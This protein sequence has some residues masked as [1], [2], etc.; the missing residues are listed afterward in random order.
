MLVIEATQYFPHLHPDLPLR[1]REIVETEE[2][3]NRRSSEL[4]QQGYSVLS[5]PMD[6][7]GEE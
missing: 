2:D 7:A 3:R 6:D 4:S 5:W 1:V